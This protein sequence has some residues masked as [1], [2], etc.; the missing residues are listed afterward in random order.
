MS[1]ALVS[2]KNSMSLKF[3]IK[4]CQ[5]GMMGPNGLIRC[6]GRVVGYLYQDAE[7]SEDFEALLEKIQKEEPHVA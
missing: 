6:N 3:T 1:A 5:G 7:N 4:F 2:G